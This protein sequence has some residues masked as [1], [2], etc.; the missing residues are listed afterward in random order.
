MT[1]PTPAKDAMHAK[2]TKAAKMKS[3]AKQAMSAKAMKA[4]MQASTANEAMRA[5]AMKPCEAGGEENGFQ[6]TMLS[7]AELSLW[8][9]D[10]VKHMELNTQ[11][12]VPPDWWMAYAPSGHPFYRNYL[13]LQTSIRIS[14]VRF[15][16]LEFDS[17]LRILMVET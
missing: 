14:G 10:I 1:T 9:P 2:A 8:D 17:D 4:A 11:I 3:M 15:T 6:R 12:F 13:E 5:K 7:L 16:A